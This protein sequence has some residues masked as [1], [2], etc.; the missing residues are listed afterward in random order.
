MFESMRKNPKRGDWASAAMKL[1]EKYE[2]NLTLQEIKEAKQGVL[3][4]L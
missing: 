2:L 1:I 4:P 3:K